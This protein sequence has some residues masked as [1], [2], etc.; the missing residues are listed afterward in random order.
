ME[1]NRIRLIQKVI[2]R[3]PLSPAQ[4]ALFKALYETNNHWIS[5]YELAYRIKVEEESMGGILG[6]LGNRIN[7]TEGIAPPLDGIGLLMIWET[8]HG[9]LHYKLL[10]ELE[11]VINNNPA[12]H[13]AIKQSV[14]EIYD[15]YADGLTIH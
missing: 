2:S 6:A 5:I 3:I 14:E 7:Q 4:I 15:N 13:D 8:Y 1:K 10:P 11:A 9:E 12:L